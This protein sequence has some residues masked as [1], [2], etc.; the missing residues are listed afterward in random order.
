MSD[1]SHGVAQVGLN[2][3]KT[4]EYLEGL[5]VKDLWF[6]TRKSGKVEAQKIEIVKAKEVGFWTSA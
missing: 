2:Y 6:L 1:D 3:K 5:D 4:L